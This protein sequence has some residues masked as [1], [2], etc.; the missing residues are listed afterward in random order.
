MTLSPS[1]KSIGLSTFYFLY[2]W[3]FQPHG[4]AASLKERELSQTQAPNRTVVF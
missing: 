4:E 1:H 3:A 2:I